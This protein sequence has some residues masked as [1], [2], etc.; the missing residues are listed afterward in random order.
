MLAERSWGLVVYV[1]YS[2]QNYIV[3][4]VSFSAQ[5]RRRRGVVV[6]ALSSGVVP[7]V[8]RVMTWK[9][10]PAFRTLNRVVRISSGALHPYTRSSDRVGWISWC[11]DVEAAITHNYDL[12]TLPR[13]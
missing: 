1:E 5:V 4:L 8:P 3:K 9:H 7:R 11:T 10:F 2:L 12:E 6:R 13:L